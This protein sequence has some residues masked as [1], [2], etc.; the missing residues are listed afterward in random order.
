MLQPSFVVVQ[1]EEQ[2][3]YA[4]VLPV[5][6]PAEARDDAVSRARVLHLDHRALA[7]LIGPVD[8]LGDHAVEPGALESCQP[9]RRQRA[10]AGHR[11]QV[12]R[13]PGIGQQPLQAPAPLRLRD[14]A[15]VLAVGR[16]RIEPDKGGRRLN[17]EP[18]DTRGGGVQ[19]HLKG[20]EIEP[21]RLWR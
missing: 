17:R 9:F 16:E 3:T 5:L 14:T 15:Q 18:G 8:R 19:A 6:V 1:A 13:R 21:V 2:G 10:I 4:R 20:I 7:G 11:G 12:N